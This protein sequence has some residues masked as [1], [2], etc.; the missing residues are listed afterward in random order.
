MTIIDE[1]IRD[2]LTIHVDDSVRSR[3]VISVLTR[4]ISLCGA[5]TYLRSENGPEFVSLAIHK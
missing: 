1:F 4:L 5:P 3:R 2:S